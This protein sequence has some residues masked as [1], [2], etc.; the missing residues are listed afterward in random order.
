[1]QALSDQSIEVL[2]GILDDQVV[3]K[4]CHS[5]HLAHMAVFCLD[6]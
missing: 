5:S 3:A 6:E 4:G 2:Q 1:M